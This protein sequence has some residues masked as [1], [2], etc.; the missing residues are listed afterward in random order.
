MRVSRI[1]QTMFN[2]LHMLHMPILN[3]GVVQPAAFLP[4]LFLARK[5]AIQA[6]TRLAERLGQT[7]M[8]DQ[9]SF[10]RIVTGMTAELIFEVINDKSR[11]KRNIFRVWYGSMCKNGFQ[12]QSS[13]FAGNGPAKPVGPVGIFGLTHEHHSKKLGKSKPTSKLSSL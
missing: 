8:K 1:G 12:R 7:C 9:R 13:L 10:R 2:Q 3:P 4:C 6:V 11:D 5:R